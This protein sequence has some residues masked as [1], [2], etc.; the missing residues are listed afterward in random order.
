MI[1]NKDTLKV[2]STSIG[3]YIVEANFGYFKLWSDDSGR[4]LAGV[5]K[6]TLIGVFPKITVQFRSLN[7]AELEIIAGLLD[8]KTQSVQ[9]YDPKQKTV[10]T[11]ST[12]TGDWESVQRNINRV[13]GF[14]CAFISI[15]KRQ[16]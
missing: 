3:K 1:L 8:S 11:M 15:A 16:E 13:K 14:S 4:N 7:Q 6:G 9:Y 2:N 10:R 12:Y 5:M